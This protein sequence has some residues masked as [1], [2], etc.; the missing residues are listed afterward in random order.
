MSETIGSIGDLTSTMDGSK[1]H[2]GLSSTDLAKLK[3]ISSDIYDEIQAVTN[4]AA[5]AQIK[6]GRL[7]N[8]A[9]ALIPGDDQFGK[10]RQE[11]TTIRSKESANKLMALARQCG[12]GRLT[13]EMVSALPISTLKELLT[14]PD[15]VIKAISDK[16]EQGEVPSKTE[17]REMV[18]ESR[19]T[20]MLE[21]LQAL[22]DYLDTGGLIEPKPA[23]A[24]RTEQ[25]KTKGPGEPAK[26]PAITEYNNVLAAVA[27]ILAKPLVKRVEYLTKNNVPFKGCTELEWAWLVFGLD[28]Q[29]A[30]LHSKEVI[31]ILCKEYVLELTGP[32]IKD[33]EALSLTLKL[34][35]DYILEEYK[36]GQ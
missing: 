17:T 5:K 23:P 27:G 7:L 19:P 28:S 14:A 21:D 25:P 18:K 15:S 4:S 26:P 13:E 6:I 10:W 9:R 16:I 2:H 24:S 35:H 12:S 33:V 11:N 1:W 22:D 3:V 31:A 8:E 30:C 34:A 32:F 20:T 36:N 29:P